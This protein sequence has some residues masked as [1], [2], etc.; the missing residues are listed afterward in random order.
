MM[1]SLFN[2]AILFMKVAQGEDADLLQIQREEKL[3]KQEEIKNKR[4]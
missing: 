3:R 1:E 4:N 2:V